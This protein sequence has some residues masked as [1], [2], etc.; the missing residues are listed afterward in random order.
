MG[1]D[2]TEQ[3]SRSDD[4][5]QK[6][7]KKYIIA[8]IIII[9]AL[10][11]GLIIYFISNRQSPTHQVNKFE[12]DVMNKKYS[13]ISKA[14]SV[15]GN[16]FS[17]SEAKSLTNYIL[18]V[19][20]EKQFKNEMSHI[21]R[22]IKS[23]NNY[24][25]DNGYGTIKDRKGRNILRFTNDGKKLFLFSKILVEP[26]YVHA[27]LAKDKQESIYKYR[28]NGEVRTA[29]TNQ[30][31]PTDIGKFVVGNYS[32]ESEKE[33]ISGAVKGK[34]RGTLKINTDDFNK[35]NKIMTKQDYSEISFKPILKNQ[36]KLKSL[37]IHINDTEESYSNSKVYGKYPTSNSIEV[38]A[39]GKIDDDVFKTN[40]TILDTMSDKNTQDIELKFD[41]SEIKKKLDE[42]NKL[43]NKAEEFMK[44]YT[45]DLTEGYK[46]VD[47]KE[48]DKYF[49]KDSDLAN[50][51]KGM[52]NTKKKSK[53]SKPKVTNIEVNGNK[54]NL[55][56]TKQDNKHNTIKS[57]YEL[58]Y[59]KSEDTFKIV[60]YTDI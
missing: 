13:N 56:L 16:E 12:S 26:N 22:N 42:Q 24:D 36:D 7:Y 33:Y 59:N 47:F 6:S 18:N 34:S 9:V 46:K 19:K 10:L 1:N 4:N 3:L 25:I 11:I 40:S 48:V 31:K 43:K 21:K 52:I 54:V 38:Y 37:K 17:E 57:K 5:E 35:D 8:A 15:N 44:D 20:G 39:S 51:I 45:D 60:N 28:Y 23:D 14:L 27:Y 53:Y 2:N 41:Q 30:S 29:K 49:E 58:K 32:L 55:I 50:H